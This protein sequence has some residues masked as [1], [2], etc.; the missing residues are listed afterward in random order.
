LDP[1]RNEQG[2]EEDQKVTPEPE[3]LVEGPASEPEVHTE[4]PPQVP[5]AE[6][7]LQAH[8]D[9]QRMEELDFLSTH[10]TPDALEFYMVDVHWLAA[11]KAFALRGAPPPGPVDNTRIV[12]ETGAP[13]QNLELKKDYR[14]VNAAIW[15]FWLGRYGGGPPIRRGSLDIYDDSLTRPPGQPQQDVKIPEIPR[16][17]EGSIPDA[18]PAPRGL[19][20]L[21]EEDDQ[22]WKDALLPSMVRVNIYDLGR[23]DDLVQAIN[24]ISTVGDTVLVG[25]VFHA[26]IE[27]FGSEWSFGGS[28]RSTTGIYRCSP[29]ACPA[30]TYHSTMVLGSTRLSKEDV[31]GVLRGMSIEWLGDSYDL[32]ERNCLSFCN[33]FCEQLGVRRIPGWVDRVPRAAS[34]VVGS[35]A[36][37][38]CATRHK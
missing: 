21:L 38:S 32:L 27:V 13:R 25:G 1:D 18:R 29:R 22:D 11:W 33:E 4:G 9:K 23:D 35:A 2:T 31:Q 14:G 30:H 24:R 8:W 19:A 28:N 15:L 3:S 7:K 12:D 17:L 26:G 34:F 5:S 6:E 16:F 37:L 20:G 10:D 36:Y